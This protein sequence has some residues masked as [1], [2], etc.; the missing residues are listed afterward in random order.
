MKTRPSVSGT[1]AAERKE[2]HIPLPILP[3]L[4]VPEGTV[5]IGSPEFLTPGLPT[6]LGIVQIPILWL[7]FRFHSYWE[8]GLLKVHRCTSSLGEM[9]SVSFPGFTNAPS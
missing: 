9:I 7:R 5:R 8:L 3:G 1:G 4:K 2:W 6:Q